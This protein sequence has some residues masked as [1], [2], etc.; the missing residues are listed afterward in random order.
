MRAFSRI[1]AKRPMGARSV[2]L[3]NESQP[4]LANNAEGRGFKSRVWVEKTD[5]YWYEALT[6]VRDG[7]VPTTTLVPSRIELYNI[8][9]LV[10]KPEVP[11]ETRG[12]FSFKT[13]KRYSGDFA[14]KLDEFSQEHG[15]DGKWWMSITEVRKQGLRLE[16]NAQPC[17]Q[18]LT[19]QSQMYNAD[20]FENPEV[21]AR[22]AYNAS[23]GRAYS[24]AIGEHLRAHADSLGFDTVLYMTGRQLENLK[25]TAPTAAIVAEVP[26]T[27]RASIKMFPL[28]EVENADAFV[29]SLQRFPVK[30][31]TFIISGQPLS[32]DLL[33]QAEAMK[34]KSHYWVSETELVNRGYSLKPN[35]KFI[36]PV[37]DEKKWLAYH[38]DQLSD[39][40]REVAIKN[41]G[42]GTI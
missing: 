6:R 36:T 28:E 29:K 18:V 13:Q 26:V 35:A 38:I 9:Q 31:H 3:L 16:M 14:R 22:R 2:V 12:H 41:I 8:D 42:R 24:E 20:Q 5:A 40:D 21:I 1:A 11:K 19:R 15:L 32:A 17:I 34:V 37:V 7:E 4:V 27:Q 33:P 39:A 30:T 25:L 10:S 23:S